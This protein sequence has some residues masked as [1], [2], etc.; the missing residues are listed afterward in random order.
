MQEVAHEC[1]APGL[2]SLVGTF[3]RAATTAVAAATATFGVADN[4][5]P[6]GCAPRPLRPVL[7]AAAA[8]TP[9]PLLRVPTPTRIRSRHRPR[10]RSMLSRSGP[11]S[12]SFGVQSRWS[13]REAGTLTLAHSFAIGSGILRTSRPGTF[14]LWPSFVWT[15]H[16]SYS[17]PQH[18][19]SASCFRRLTW[20]RNVMVFAPTSVIWPHEHCL[21]QTAWNRCLGWAGAVLIT[22]GSRSMRPRALSKD[23]KGAG[24]RPPGRPA[25]LR[26]GGEL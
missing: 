16:F 12:F 2:V 9:G 3:G 18:A 11:S 24:V 14:M 23:M 10:V 26:K 22:K 15:M 19:S 5:M 8:R 7:R 6:P 20:S 13:R 4:H 25:L 1:W 21:L 17:R